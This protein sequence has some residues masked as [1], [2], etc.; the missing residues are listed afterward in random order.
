MAAQKK[1][2]VTVKREFR[3][4][5]TKNLHHVG[6][7]LNITQRRYDEIISKDPTLVSVITD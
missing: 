2:T 7:V 6:D 4:K 3:D 5:R 1:L